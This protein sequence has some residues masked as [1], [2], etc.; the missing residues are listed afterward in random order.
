MPN[1]DRAARPQISVY[2]SLHSE[3]W[4]YVRIESLGTRTS[5]VLL[6]VQVNE[7]CSAVPAIDLGP[8]LIDLPV[9]PQYLQ[10]DFCLCPAQPRCPLCSACSA[11]LLLRCGGLH[12]K[13][14]GVLIRCTTSLF[15]THGHI[16]VSTDSR[17][18]VSTTS[19]LRYPCFIRLVK[20]E[21]CKWYGIISL[22]SWV[23]HCAGLLSQ[24][25]TARCGTSS[26]AVTS[27]TL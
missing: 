17:A 2:T 9:K 18:S 21:H 25:D 12:E 19:Y 3:A 1:L 20:A 16:L 5:A 27:S 7:E 26:P 4:Q 8:I 13:C 23:S 15:W 14:L 11:C 6:A 22:L 24:K 10:A